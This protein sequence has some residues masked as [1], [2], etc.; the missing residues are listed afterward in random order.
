MLKAFIE[1]GFENQQ[2]YRH[3]N[4]TYVSRKQCVIAALENELRQLEKNHPERKIGFVTFNNDVSV[5]GDGA[6]RDQVT[7]LTGD[8][9]D[10]YEELLQTVE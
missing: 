3:S 5:I 9:L 6:S 8:K 10:N 4:K 1:P 7:V 2:W